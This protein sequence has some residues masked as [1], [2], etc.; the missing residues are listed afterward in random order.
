MC[1]SPHPPVVYFSRAWAGRASD[2]HI[3]GQSQN[4]IAALKPGE[5]A[6]VDR[7]FAIERTLP[8][9]SVELV[10]PDFK[11]QG[12]SQLRLREKCRGK[13]WKQESMWRG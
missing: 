7:G 13:L 6:M 1:V 5:Q 12:S 8:L 11:G 2:K 10:I 3:P 4:L 9:R